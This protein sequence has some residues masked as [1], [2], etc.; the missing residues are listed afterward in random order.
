VENN[1]G[2]AGGGGVGGTTTTISAESSKDCLHEVAIPTG[3]AYTPMSERPAVALKPAKEYPFPLDPFQREAIKCIDRSE[4]VL[5]S[6]HTSAG[7]TV[8]AEYAIATALRDG[9]RVIYTSPIKALSNQKYRDLQEEFGD[10]GLMT[11]DVTISPSAACL[12]MTTE[13]LRS[14]LYR[15]SEVMREVGWV[16]FDEVHYM[17]DKER[18]VVWEETLILLPHNVHYVFLSATIPNSLQFAR[19]I[20]E[21]HQQP[22]HVVYT[23]YRPTPL[24]HYLFPAGADGLY[25]VVDEHGTFREDSF[26]RAMS[27]LSSKPAEDDKKGKKGG[28]K[29]PSEVKR[30]LELVMRKKL[31]PVIVFSF[32]KR[33]CEDHAKALQKLDFTTEEEKAA[34][35]TVFNSAIDSLSE[36]DRMLPQVISVLP[37]LQRG[38]GIHHGGLLPILKEV[39]EI[40]FGEGL[41]K[42]LFATETFAMGLNMPARTV[43]FTNVRKFDGKDFRWLSGG[44]YI[45]MSG[46]AGRRGKDDK[47][48]VFLMC[49]EKMEEPVGKA[50][51]KGQA[52]KLDSA[53]HLTYNMVLNLLRV[54]E[55][56]PEYM[57]ERCFFQF[58]NQSALP[59]KE[60]KLL[61]LAKN[62]DAVKMKDE[63]AV[64]EYHLIKQ[65]LVV[66]QKQLRDIVMQPDHVVP[67]LNPGRLVEVK[68]EDADWG[69]GVIVNFSK[70]QHP[71]SKPGTLGGSYVYIVE[72]LL[73]C[74]EGTE[75][76]GVPRP[77]PEGATGEFAVVPVLLELLNQVRF[78]AASVLCFLCA[79]LSPPHRAQCD[80]YYLSASISTC[81]L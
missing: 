7:K 10:V 77:C 71:Q 40:L 3:Y 43:I 58:Q 31:D 38:I 30:L 36:D 50:L 49:D 46:R 26:S 78:D 74:A 35:T 80:L 21:L 69:W 9:Q 24:V 72:V 19:W 42:V 15:G 75:E 47:G 76:T 56:N 52:D 73:H 64:A 37:F 17:R 16:V 23:N 62:R 27:L 66:L 61:E 29:Q 39:I 53:F 11:G 2:A 67:F 60:T 51:L 18:G 45:Q 5:V 65:Q 22:C 63:A 20:C 13:I 68:S 41:V 79:R 81:L 4:S 54:E 25:I 70:K 6:A 48:L 33:D 14:M 34:V 1:S 32:S 28:N 57:L 44:E 8:T 55:L 59:A 12:V